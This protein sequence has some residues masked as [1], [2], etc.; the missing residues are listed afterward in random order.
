MTA[1]RSGFSLA[2]DD[3]STLVADLRAINDGEF[4]RG[5]TI[6]TRSRFDTGQDD[7]KSLELGLCGE[8]GYVY[9]TGGNGVWIPEGGGADDW[10]ESWWWSGHNTF[11]PPGSKV[12]AEVALAVVAEF[13]E[14]RELPTCV[15]WVEFVE[16]PYVF[17]ESNETAESLAN[18]RL[19]IEMGWD[20]SESG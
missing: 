18:R 6:T 14:T 8:D 16:P 17:D 13:V 1:E 20:P 5:W 4:V 7:S 10:V 3:C 11:L 12:S 19:L 15:R 9:W 2:D